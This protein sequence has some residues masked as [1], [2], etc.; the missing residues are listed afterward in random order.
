MSGFRQSALLSATMFAVGTFASHG[1]ADVVQVGTGVSRVGTSVMFKSVLAI[2]GD[3][4]TIT[5][6]NESP[7]ASM[8]PDDL[9]G[10]YYFDIVKPGNIRP[11][12]T[13]VSAVGDVYVGNRSGPDPLSASAADLRA[14]NSGDGTWQFQTMNPASVPFTGFGLGTVGNSALVNSFNGNIVGGIDYSIARGEV[15]TANLNGRSI[16]KGA[17]TFTFTG[18]SGFSEA[19]VASGFAY[20]L[21]T[22]PDSIISV[23][24]PAGVSVLAAAGLAATRRRRAIR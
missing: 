12:L 3:T 7:A 1:L 2:S 19:D 20:G 4:L 14:V 17:I 9:L 13:Y 23:P 8:A 6:T 24:G 18:V 15:T 21:G 22:A 10:S 16:V 5:L 11:T